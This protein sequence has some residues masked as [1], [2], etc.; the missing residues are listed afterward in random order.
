[1]KTL[2]LDLGDKHIGI[3]ISDDLELF[4]NPYKTVDAS[5]LEEELKKIFGDEEIETVVIGYPKTMR[6]T[7]SEQTLK[8]ENSKIELETTFPNKKWILW[9]ERLTSKSAQNLKKIQNRED[10]LKIHAIAAAIIL[11]SYLEG[12]RF[13]Y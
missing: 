13:N 11:S 1:M 10:K 9:D 6:N 3:A 4:A 2:A 7:K 5:K 8:V 12:K